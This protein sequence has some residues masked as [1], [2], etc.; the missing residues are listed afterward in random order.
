MQFENISSDS[1]SSRSNVDYEKVAKGAEQ[2]R[3]VIHA[4]VAALVAD[5]FSDEQARE[6][7]AGLWRVAGRGEDSDA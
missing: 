3:E 4:M 2:M 6:I 1:G 7:I 5:G